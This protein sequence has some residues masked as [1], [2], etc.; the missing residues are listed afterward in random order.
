MLNFNFVYHLFHSIVHENENKSIFTRV[1]EIF[2]HR[3]FI[4]TMKWRNKRIDST[5][6][7]NFWKHWLIALYRRVQYNESLLPLRR[8]ESN[9]MA[10]VRCNRWP[11]HSCPFMISLIQ[12]RT[13][14]VRLPNYFHAFIR[15]INGRFDLFRIKLGKNTNVNV[16]FG[17]SKIYEFN[18]RFE[19]NLKIEE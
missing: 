15:N 12:G 6:E 11:P 10:I 3:I 19:K 9:G 18:N 16:I 1:S 7:R 5:T 13:Y 2:Q 8:Y 14:R 17:Y 4:S